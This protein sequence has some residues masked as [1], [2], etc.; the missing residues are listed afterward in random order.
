MAGSWI[1]PGL[2][3]GAGLEAGGNI[4]W[5][6]LACPCATGAL[7]ATSEERVEEEWLETKP[8]SCTLLPKRAQSL[9]RK[10]ALGWWLPRSQRWMVTT[11][12]PSFSARSCCRQ[13]CWTRSCRKRSFQGAVCVISI[14]L[15]LQTLFRS[16]INPQLG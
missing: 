15:I 1:R 2:S 10:Y 4:S 12:V 16:F 3:A 6:G 7:T 5:A 14:V 8:S 9:T 11:E 13:L